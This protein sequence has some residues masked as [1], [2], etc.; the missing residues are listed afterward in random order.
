MSST[1]PSDPYEVLGVARDADETTIKKAFRKLARE[2]HPDVNSHDPDAEE[3][4]K[5]AAEAYE[6]LSDA[7][8]RAIYDRYGH[9]GLRSGGQAPNFDGFGSITDLFDAFFGG[10]FGGG[11]RTGP[12]QGD[13]VAVAID[14]DLEQAY[15]G[16]K[17]DVSFEAIDRC[18]HCRGNGAEPGTPI[19]T[20]DK[21]AG[22]GVLQAV[23]RSP[24]G[25][26]VRQVACDKCGGDGKIA[27]TPCET[28][29]GR[30]LVVGHRRLQVDIPAGI[31]DGQRI[32]L[33]GRGHAGEHGGPP[34]DLYVVV[35]VALGDGWLR[36]DDDLIT[37]ADLPAPLAAL[38]TTVAIPHPDGEIAVEI[39]AGTQPGD[40]L[41]VRGK[42]MPMLRRQG[43][44]GDLRVVANVVIPRRLTA[45]QRKL[46][47]ALAESVTPEQLRT[48][49]DSMV[50]KLRRLFHR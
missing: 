25:Q 6:I 48:D 22:H 37:V 20:C 7:E 39:P 16:A 33:S 35:Q 21:C 30:G 27:E 17:V 13:D 29:D 36:D 8:R 15:R 34:G 43:R 11:A 10:S 1:V 46:L 41:T 3:K 32:R 4:F 28:C 50:G 47:T 38:G 49:D 18:E 40:V 31:A 24:F 44:S 42:G 5:A 12:R 14:V 2:L 45:E 26:V 9:E 19:T 23:T